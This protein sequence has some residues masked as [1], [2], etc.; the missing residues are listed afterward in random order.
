VLLSAKVGKFLRHGEVFDDFFAGRRGREMELGWAVVE[1]QLGRGVERE[2]RSL[3]RGRAFLGESS[4][5]LRRGF[6]CSAWRRAVRAV[7]VAS[8]CRVR[9]ALSGATALRSAFGCPKALG[10]HDTHDGR[11]GGHRPTARRKVGQRLRCDQATLQAIEK[12][13][14]LFAAM[15]TTRHGRSE[16][17]STC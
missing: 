1:A 4:L 3:A 6:S 14:A 8:L 9:A 12:A 11:L 13:V 7:A 17:A 16:L 10:R 15:R 2:D 5:K